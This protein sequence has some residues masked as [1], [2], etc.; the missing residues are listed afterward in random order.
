MRKI[1]HLL[2]LMMIRAFFFIFFTLAAMVPTLLVAQLS[3]RPIGQSTHFQKTNSRISSVERDS[4][5]LELPFW[6]DFSRS[7]Y[8]PDSLHWFVE[9]GT[10]NVSSSVGIDP[11][12]VN[13]AV[14]DGWNG[15]GMPYSSQLLQEGGGDSLVSRYIDLTKV[16]PSL[17][18][19]VYIS[20]FWQK[21]GRGEMPDDEDSIR[22][23][24]M[25]SEKVWRTVWKKAGKDVTMNDVFEQEI[26]QVKDPL[27]GIA[28][29]ILIDTRFF[30]KI[31]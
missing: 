25:N 4:T 24:V 27:F 30:Q 15:M 7:T 22:L 3:V 31:T 17:W 16:N 10:S 2:Y 29:G 1:Y 23:Q 18:E 9:E 19:T 21:E 28:D 26:I 14:F 12:T 20:F 8:L 5:Q 6:D 11:P 13:V